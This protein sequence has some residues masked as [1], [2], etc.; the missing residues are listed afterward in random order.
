MNF[1]RWVQWLCIAL[2]T[3][4]IFGLLFSVS[5]CAVA[6][7]PARPAGYDPSSVVVRYI[8]NGNQICSAVAVGP[9]RVLT[10]GH[11]PKHDP[12]ARIEIATDSGPPHLV[13]GVDDH[14]VLDLAVL[15]LAADLEPP[16]A[17]PAERPPEL[18]RVLISGYGCDRARGR[19][20]SRGLRSGLFL[21]EV[22]DSA[23]DDLP[24]FVTVGLG[25]HGDSGGALM[26][27]R[28]ELVG[29]IWGITD[30]SGIPV[31]IATDARA[32]FHN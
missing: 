10:A 29:V 32:Y 11:C 18:E 17:V 6:P 16:Y 9:R 13:V 25:C 8:E 22:P 3:G 26:N 1:E 24:D 2:L 28:G 30:L 23:H 21:G 20:A 4:A 15:T 14:P 5:G 31:V 7:P 19:L 27:E 12:A